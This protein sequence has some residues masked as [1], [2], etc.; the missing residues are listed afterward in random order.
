MCPKIDPV[1]P[2]MPIL[3]RMRQRLYR[4][5]D[6]HFNATKFICQRFDTFAIEIALIAGASDVSLHLP[7]LHRLTSIAII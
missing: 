6:A 4:K 1:F 5:S 2:I 7:T 3:M